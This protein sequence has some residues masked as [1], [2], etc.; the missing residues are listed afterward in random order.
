MQGPQGSQGDETDGKGWRGKEDLDYKVKSRFE[1]RSWMM[2]I[3]GRAGR[4]NTPA[5]QYR[6]RMRGG[7]PAILFVGE[8]SIAQRH[9]LG[10]RD[11]L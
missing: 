7:R 8:A 1:E 10:V 4:F 9:L 6:F 11:W 2:R 3:D 5:F